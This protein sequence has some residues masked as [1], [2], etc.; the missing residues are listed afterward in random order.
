MNLK[1]VGLFELIQNV[2]PC[3]RC[4][5]VCVDQNTASRNQEA[6]S[7]LANFRGKKMPFGICLEMCSQSNGSEVVEVG[8]PIISDYSEDSS[9]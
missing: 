3:Y 9:L 4:Q 2:G 6:L 8:C 1:F 5:M 7:V